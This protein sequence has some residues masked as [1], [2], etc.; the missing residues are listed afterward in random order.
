MSEVAN[1]ALKLGRIKWDQV[2]EPM[3][4][5]QDKISDVLSSM[6][7]TLDPLSFINAPVNDTAVSKFKM[8]M[9]ATVH[10]HQ[11]FLMICGVKMNLCH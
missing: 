1:E 3:P 10:C 8:S 7:S 4:V 9:G 6:S 2:Y 5:K 11:I